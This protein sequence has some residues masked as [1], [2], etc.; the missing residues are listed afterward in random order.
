ML[1]RKL[2]S[3]PNVTILVSAQTTEVIGDGAKVTALTYKD[4]GTGDMHRVELEGIFVQIGL[5]PNTEWLKGALD[6][7]P[8]GE[9]IIDAHGATSLPGVYA[10]G[11][12]TTVPYKQ[13]IIAM[14]AGATAALGAFDYMM[15]QSAPS[16]T[17]VSVA[18]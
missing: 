2:R 16:E 14:G 1:Q 4:R 11:D 7:S 13:I 17:N 8:R 15:R 9:I 18:A 12:A 3:L 6:L 5:L 10:A